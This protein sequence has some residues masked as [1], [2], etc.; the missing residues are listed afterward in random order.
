MTNSSVAAIADRFGARRIIPLAAVL[1]L[2]LAACVPLPGSPEPAPATPTGGAQP[3]QP[4]ETSIPAAAAAQAALA[5]KLG[6]P[7][8]QITILSVEHVEWPDAC[9]GAA[10]EGVMCAQVITPGYR[11]V[12]EVD[13]KQYEAHTDESGQTVQVVNP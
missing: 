7:E 13:G 1:C 5:A 9:L 10:D 2:L 6:V 4:A 12:M 11:I 8:S 3:A